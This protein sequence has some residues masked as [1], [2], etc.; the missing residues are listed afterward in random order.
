[1]ETRPYGDSGNYAN[2][3][4]IECGACHTVSWRPAHNPGSALRT[5]RR[6]GWKVGSKPPQHRCPDCMKPARDTTSADNPV[7]PKEIGAMLKT[8]IVEHRVERMMASP[9]RLT[10]QKPVQAPVRQID[11]IPPPPSLEAVLPPTPPKRG[12]LSTP[13]VTL[14]TRRDNAARSGA[15]A[16]GGTDGVEFFTIPVG[17]GW[18][19]KRVADVTDDEK[20]AWLPRPGRGGYRARPAK[21]PPKTIEETPVTVVPL[22]PRKDPMPTIEPAPIASS[23]PVPS[24]R[25]PTRDERNTIHEALTASYDI[26]AQRYSGEVSDRAL[27]E[28]LSVPR[29]WVRDLREQFFGDFDRNDQ[30][31]AKKK[32]LDEAIVLASE[33]VKRLMEMAAEC[34]TIEQSLRKL[35]TRLEG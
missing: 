3:A 5:F 19:W 25:E 10:P 35:R 7:I 6:L 26:V 28:R 14:F 27:A 20:K 9:H 22:T 18:T 16:T 24:G 8:Q 4:S 21:T 11:P 2:H 13:G 1:M 17:E 31:E 32:D 33:A 12:V 23:T 30:T 15:S 29:V 34:E